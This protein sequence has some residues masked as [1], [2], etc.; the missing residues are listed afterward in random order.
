MIRTRQLFILVSRTD[1][2]IAQVIRTFSRYPYNHVSLTLDPSLRR[3]YSFAR[4]VQD[5]PF[6][7]GFICEPVER[8]YA[9]NGDAQVRLYRV[10][11][12]SKTAEELEA[13]MDKASQPDSGLIY[14]YFD[15][16]A[17]AMG[18]KLPITG[19]HTCL[20][21][22]CSILE[23]QHLSIKSL[24]RDLEP[25]MIYEGALSSLI[26]DS[27]RRD[28]LYFTR[29]G[30]LHGTALSAKQLALLTHRMVAQ[31]FDIYKFLV[32]HRTAH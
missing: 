29:L 19:S 25:S 24:C 13:L 30:F 8:F 11:I 7:S 27:G 10:E 23:R 22:A 1:T 16:L 9:E 14:N 32:S 2:G 18:G 31:A 6:Y 15:A 21:F 28:D 12:P 5:T 3:W 17:G 26:P 4:Y 20:S